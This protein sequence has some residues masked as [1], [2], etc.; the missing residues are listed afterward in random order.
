MS[1]LSFKGL[2]T[3]LD[4]DLLGCP[5]DSAPEE[6]KKSYDFIDYQKTFLS[7]E[8]GQCFLETFY[9]LTINKIITVWF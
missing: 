3:L 5:G 1:H 2:I 4:F 7:L 6:L 8:W 9:I